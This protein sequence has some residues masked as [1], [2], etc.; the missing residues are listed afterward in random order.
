[1]NDI[2]SATK[3]NKIM[4]TTSKY[5]TQGRLKNPEPINAISPFVEGRYNYISVRENGQIETVSFATNIS[6]EYMMSIGYLNG[7]HLLPN[8][9]MIF[10][11]D[12]GS[13]NG[14]KRNAPVSNYLGFTVYGPC[15]FTQQ[16]AKSAG[17]RRK[18][19][20]EILTGLLNSK[21]PTL[22]ELESVI[23][24]NLT[25]LEYPAEQWAALDQK[26][27]LHNIGVSDTMYGFIRQLGSQSL[28]TKYVRRL[29][30]I[31]TAARKGASMRKDVQIHIG[32][33]PEEVV[34]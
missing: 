7:Y 12:E 28:R 14:M 23:D 8:K 27:F 11:S 2:A 24:L 16:T 22:H 9:T 31:R 6:H 15:I 18:Q 4:K 25:L 30:N 5:D 33:S 17:L 1:M 10:W 21:Q 32:Y 13:M 34:A 3:D 19:F 29:N 20:D 26:E